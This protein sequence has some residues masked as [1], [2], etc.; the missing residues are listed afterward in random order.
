MATGDAV[1]VNDCVTPMKNEKKD[2]DMNPTFKSQNENHDV[3]RCDETAEDF[4][5]MHFSYYLNG[6]VT[7]YRTSS[8][9]WFDVHKP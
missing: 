4:F 8:S 9:Y 3:V 6:V 1:E 2:S 7:N 5:G